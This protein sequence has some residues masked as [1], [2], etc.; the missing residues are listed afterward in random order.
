[1]PW[2]ILQSNIA[3]YK[4][5]LSQETDPKTIATVHRLLAEEEDKLAAYRAKNLKPP[6][7]AANDEPR[8][9][10]T[11][12]EL[13]GLLASSS[14]PVIPQVTNR[15]RQMMLASHDPSIIND[16]LFISLVMIAGALI[17]ALAAIV[18]FTM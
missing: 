9:Y 15:N 10:L 1:M 3:H 12:R 2:F 13:A 18:I 11:D 4:E 6:G 14:H 16:R 7:P 17:V 5:R 8:E